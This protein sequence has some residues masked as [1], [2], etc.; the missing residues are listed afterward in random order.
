MNL[1]GIAALLVSTYNFKVKILFCLKF[2]TGFEVL[3]KIFCIRTEGV[4]TIFKFGVVQNR[5]WFVIYIYWCC[6][7]CPVGNVLLYIQYKYVKKFRKNL[8]L[9]NQGVIFAVCLTIKKF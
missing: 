8:E 3:L 1:V 5:Y 7:R 2:L 9:A 4:L 6:I